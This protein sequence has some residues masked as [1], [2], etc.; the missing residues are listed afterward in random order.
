MSETKDKCFACDRVLGRN[1]KQADTRDDQVVLVGSECY[2]KIKAAGEQGYQP[3][4]GGPR[5]FMLP[6]HS[7]NC[8]SRF[9]NS[10]T[11]KSFP[12]DCKESKSQ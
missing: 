3:P 9:F 11:G 1:P 2:S 4:K 12:C 7:G 6:P 8:G 10:R 5:L